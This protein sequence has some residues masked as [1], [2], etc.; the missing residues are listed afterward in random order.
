MGAV[1]PGR[2]SAANL[3]TQREHPDHAA[4]RH[5]RLRAAVT[6]DAPQHALRVHAP[7]G[8]HGDVLHAVHFERRRHAGDA[9][10]RPVLPQQ[11]AARGVERAEV[12]VAGAAGE[13]EPARR[14]HDGPPV[15]RLEI[16]GPYPLAGGEVPGLQL[17]DV[18]GAVDDA[19]VRARAGEVLA[20]A[21]LDFLALHLL[22]QV[23][24]RGDVQV[25]GLRVVGRRRPVLAAPQR[26]A[27]LRAMADGGLARHVVLGPARLRVDGR[28]DVLRDVRLRVDERDAVRRALQNPQIAVAARVHEAG[29]GTAVALHVDQQRRRDLVPVPRAVPVVLVIAAQLAGLDVER[30]D[31]VRIEVVAGAHV[32]RPRPGIAGAPERQAEPG[33]VAAG[34]PHRRAAGLPRVLRPRVVTELAGA[35]N[36]IRLPDLVARVR[37][38]RDDEAADA[39]LAARHT[40]HDPPLRGERRERHVVAAVVVLDRALP[41]HL[42]GRGVERDD[43]RVAGRRVDLVAVQRDAPVRRVPHA[44]VRRQSMPITPQQVAGRGIEREHLVERRRDEHHAVVDD[45]RRLVALGGAGRHRPHRHEVFDI[46]CR[47]VVERAVAPRV[48]GAQIHQPVAVFRPDQALVR[49]RAVRADGLCG[50]DGRREA[51]ERD[52]QAARR[53]KRHPVVSRTSAVR[54]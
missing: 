26:R 48:V 27:E 40:D 2:T 22:A 25:A 53:A 11:L 52:Q 50:G 43:L 36:R 7:A 39:A 6:V 49:D 35:R 41:C 14:R 3:T 34:D 20:A 33:V 44:Q 17:A 16:V 13:H 31:G 4:L 18:I 47:D 29:H 8:L 19:E 12:A 28:E 46:A 15:R 1:S 24:V 23:L 30:D 10:I 21:V 38:E 37:V 9:G 32:A 5:D 54:G 45:R 51:G 42:A